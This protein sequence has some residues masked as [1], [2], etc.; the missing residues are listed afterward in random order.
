MPPALVTFD[1]FGT[2]ID[3]QEGMR[4]DLARLGI[5]LDSRLFEEVLADQE[6]AEKALVFQ[7]YA[8]IVA[9]S[10]SRRLGVPPP[11]ALA[12]GRHA[13]TWPLFADASDSL[14]ALAAHVPCVA[15]TNSDRIHGAQVQKQLGFELSGWLCAEDLRLYKP[16]PAFWQQA[17]KAR[18]VALGK[19]WWHVSAYADYDLTPAR[20]L[21][22]TTVFLKRPHTRPGP[23]D[24]T[25]DSLRQLLSIVLES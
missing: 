25:V 18:G 14:R 15:L 1:I 21:G 17:A 19:S 10:L 4:A 16:A 22:L 3:W 13:G 12:I 2:I 11:E 20:N 24:M 7:T 8:E 23:A 6:R 9:W 5:T